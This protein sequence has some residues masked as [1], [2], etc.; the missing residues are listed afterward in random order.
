MT[1]DWSDFLAADGLIME[2]ISILLPP[3][4]RLSIFV[5]FVILFLNLPNLRLYTSQGFRPYASQCCLPHLFL[6]PV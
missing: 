2:H 1:S 6:L 3:D 5:I 4:Y